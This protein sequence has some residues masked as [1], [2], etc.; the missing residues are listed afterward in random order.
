MYTD[1]K[2]TL[3]YEV[4]GVYEDVRCSASSKRENF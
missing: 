4:E 1:P 3:T 2:G